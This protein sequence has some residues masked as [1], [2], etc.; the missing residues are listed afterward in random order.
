VDERA[1]RRAGHRAGAREAR[2]TRRASVVPERQD[3]VAEVDHA[4]AVC[5]EAG[6]V[7]D[8]R[9]LLAVLEQEAAPV[10]GPDELVLVV[11]GVAGIAEAV[12]VDVDLQFVRHIHAVVADVADVVPIAVRGGAR[13]QPGRTARQAGAGEA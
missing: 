10:G 3:G 5:V 11:V 1:E 12:A 6:I 2:G 7:T 13:T 8:G 4:V 9:P